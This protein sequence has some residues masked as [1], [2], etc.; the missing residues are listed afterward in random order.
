[1]ASE[2]E[3][4]RA[5]L[6][7]A[8]R[9]TALTGAG[10]SADSGVPTFR[11]PAGLWRD[12]R[13]EELATAEAFARNPKLVWEWYDWRRTSIATKR[14]N[15]GHLALAALERRSADFKLITQNVDGLHAAAGHRAP[16]E[17]HGNLWR[18]R[19]TGCGRVVEDRRMPLPLPPSCGCGGLQ[20]PDVIWFGEALQAPVLDQ[21]V[22]ALACDVLLVVGTSGAVQPAA[23][24]GAWARRNGAFVIELNPQPS[25]AAAQLRLAGRAAELLPALFAPS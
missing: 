13:A 15:A 6:A 9:V 7:R 24:F 5:R 22:A 25:C 8:R 2:L 10:V 11:G 17:L 20:R 1:M 16:I 18:L 3:Q 4:A 23:S 14:P 12:F 21:A 19:C